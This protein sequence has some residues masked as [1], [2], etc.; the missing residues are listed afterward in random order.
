MNRPVYS[1]RPVRPSRPAVT[2]HAHL[3][4]SGLLSML[5]IIGPLAGMLGLGMKRHRKAK[6]SGKHRKAR[7]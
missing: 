3:A 1:I 5:P 7:K 6:G 4:G 2:T